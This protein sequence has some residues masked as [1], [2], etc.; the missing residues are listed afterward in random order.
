[1]FSYQYIKCI[2]VKAHIKKTEDEKAYVVFDNLLRLFT[3]G[4]VEII[5]K[6]AHS[7]HHIYNTLR[8]L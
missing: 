4:G 5:Y 3:Q 2:F 7:P 6:N 1:M 8:V